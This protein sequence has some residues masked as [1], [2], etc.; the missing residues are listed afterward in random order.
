MSEINV[1]LDGTT[2]QLSMFDE[3]PGAE[4]DVWQAVF[5]DDS[6]NFLVC[7]FEADKDCERLDLIN[8]A[9]ENLRDAE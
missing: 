2:L 1:E 6:D 3:G 9:I 7:Y 5:V 4:P 8:L